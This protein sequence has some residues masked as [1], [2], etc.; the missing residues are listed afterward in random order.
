[1]GITPLSSFYLFCLNNEQREIREH[2]L[3]Q[4]LHS[5]EI[6]HPDIFK[7]L[8]ISSTLHKDGS[9]VGKICFFEKNYNTENIVHDIPFYQV[10]FNEILQSELCD[11]YIYCKYKEKLKFFYFFEKEYWR[12]TLVANEY[13]AKLSLLYIKGLLN[14]QYIPKL[15]EKIPKT[16]NKIEYKQNSWKNIINFCKKDS[17]FSFAIKS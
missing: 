8:S 2:K 1:M 7:K 12:R 5:Y 6:K 16:Q 11:S 14:Q 13:F 17:C 4:H 9:Y 15:L 10:I 3:L